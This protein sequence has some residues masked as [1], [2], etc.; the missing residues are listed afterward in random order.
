MSVDDKIVW[1]GIYKVNHNR[2]NTGDSYNDQIYRQ[3]VPVRRMDGSIWMQDTYQISYT[4]ISSEDIMDSICNYND[5]EKGEWIIK[6]SSNWYYP[7]NEIITGYDFRLSDYELICDLHEYRPLNKVEDVRHYTHTDVIY[8]I[9]LANEHGYSFAYGDNG[10]TLVKLDAQPSVY[11]E[12]LAEMKDVCNDL[13]RPYECNIDKM[14]VLHDKCVEQGLS[15]HPKDLVNYKNILYINRRLKEMRRELDMYLEH[16]KYRPVFTYK[17]ESLVSLGSVHQDM[18]RYLRE[19]CYTPGE[20]QDVNNG[21]EVFSAYDKCKVVYLDRTTIVVI[22]ASSDIAEPRILLFKVSLEDKI[23]DA[24]RLDITVNN[25][26]IIKDI[27]SKDAELDICFDCYTGREYP[28]EIDDLI[29]ELCK[30][31]T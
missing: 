22:S 16:N 1:G 31:N 13:Q 17:S 23:V 6:Y 14:K 18:T 20:I 24:L 15:I 21:Y 11:N 5:P 3:A 9:H 30:V 8:R 27:I 2:W 12:W 26:G 29:E 4:G 25:V 28:E 19:D 7:S 10:I